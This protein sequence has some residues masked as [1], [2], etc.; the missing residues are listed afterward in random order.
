MSGFDSR[1]SSYYGGGY[2]QNRYSQAGG[3]YYGG[4]QGGAARES[5]AENG[6]GPRGGPRTR[7]NP[8]RMQ[9]DPGW[10]RYSN[11]HNVY[12]SQGHQQPRDTVVAGGSNGSLSE[13]HSADPSSENSS[14]ERG[15]PVNKPDMGEQYGFSGFGGGPQPILEE[16]GN[17]AGPSNNGYF[18]PQHNAGNVPP[19]VPMKTAGP[20]PPPAHNP[21][22]IKLTN[23]QGQGPPPANGGRPNV[24]SRKS[25]EAS[26]KRRSWFKRRF[27][28]D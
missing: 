25:T 13:P 5:W 3:G 10:N 7:Y 12:P 24:L 18:P 17:D 20:P 6:Y 26:D 1:R 27:S 23:S 2:E 22:M 14:I 4:R 16:Y 11:G 28:K 19:P 9:S 15:Y 8:N 21:N